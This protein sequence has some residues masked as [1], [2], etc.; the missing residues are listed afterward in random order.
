MKNSLFLVLG[1]LYFFNAE[2]CRALEIDDGIEIDDSIDDYHDMGK[3]Q[4]NVN[5]VVR[6]SLS[7]A[8]L[9][10]NTDK[11]S[12]NDQRKLP[13]NISVD[14]IIV[15]DGSRVQGDIILIDQSRGNKAAI[16]SR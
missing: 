12:I 6:N 7:R 5:Y 16:S 3:I 11:M 4:K 9:R 1:V 10:M 2:V 13:E 14:S 8:Y 15:G